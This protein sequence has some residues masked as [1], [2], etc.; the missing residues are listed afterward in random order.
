MND[1]SH[2]IEPFGFLRSAGVHRHAL[3]HV[4][5]GLIALE[6][7]FRSATAVP[8]LVRADLGIHHA[9]EAFLR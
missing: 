1:R 9:L 6:A 4:A 2:R 3:I 5:T 8:A 7:S